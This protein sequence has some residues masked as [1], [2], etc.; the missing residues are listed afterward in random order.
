MEDGD[1]D[2]SE[3]GLDWDEMEE[4]ALKEDKLKRHN[5]EEIIN[6]RKRPKKN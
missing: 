3:E 6:T 4:K 5:E 1:N 2:L